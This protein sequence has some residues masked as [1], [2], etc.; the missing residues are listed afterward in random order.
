L[1]NFGPKGGWQGYFWANRWMEGSFV[2]FPILRGY[3]RPFSALFSPFLI[4][5]SL[6]VFT[7]GDIL[8]YLPCSELFFFFYENFHPLSCCSQ[9]P[10]C[11]F[12][13]LM[14]RFSLPCSCFPKEFSTHYLDDSPS[15][16]NLVTILTR[17]EWHSHYPLVAEPTNYYHTIY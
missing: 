9:N 11:V 4:F 8:S 1:V 16:P 2:P 7:Y 6:F 5:S 12:H 14:M 17:R 10:F 3:F 13:V 15:R